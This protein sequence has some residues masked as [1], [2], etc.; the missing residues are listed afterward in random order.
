[1]YNQDYE[2]YMRNV[3]GYSPNYQDITYRD[4]DYYGVPNQSYY[5]ERLESMY[6]EIYR[7]VYPLILREVGMNSRAVTEDTI[8]EIVDR[9]YNE[10]EAEQNNRA[11]E[12]ERI[13]S[14]SSSISSSNALKSAK[15]SETNEDRQ[16][17]VRP[18]NNFL[19][20]LIRILLLRE[21]LG[22]PGFPHRPPRPG[23]PPFP[24]GPG[25]PPPRPRDYYM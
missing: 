18:R 1:M 15:N 12:N 16:F 3:L 8:E 9:I 25:M 10:V 5:N 2:E 22:R 4:N 17:V 19:R 7:T 6:P 13:D 14:K 21:L 11:I 24:G 23:R 20:D